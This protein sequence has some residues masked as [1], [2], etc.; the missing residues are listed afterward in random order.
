MLYSSERTVS[1]HLQHTFEKLNV[2]SSLEAVS[3]GI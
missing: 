1:N 3:K 2:S